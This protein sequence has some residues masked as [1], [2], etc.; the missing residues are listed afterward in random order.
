MSKNH[1]VQLVHEDTRITSA[2]GKL[3][4]IVSDAFADDTVST[5]SD[6]TPAL[7]PDGTMKYVEDLKC[8]FI[9]DQN[10]T[11]APD[12]ITIIDSDFGGNWLRQNPAPDAWGEQATWYI[13]PVTGIDTNTGIDAAHAIKTLVEFQR[14][15]NYRVETTM[16]VNVIGS[17][18]NTDPLPKM[19]DVTGDLTIRSSMVQRTSGQLTGY[20]DA[21]PSTNTLP[22]ITKAAGDWSTEIGRIIHFIESDSWAYVIYDNGAGAASISQPGEWSA[23]YGLPATPGDTDHF[24]TYDITSTAYLVDGS[25]WR[26]SGKFTIEGFVICSDGDYDT[27]RLYAL[28]VWSYLTNCAIQDG[29]A[30]IISS[31]YVQV[32]VLRVGSPNQIESTW[33]ATENASTLAADGLVLMGTAAKQS[34]LMVSYSSHAPESSRLAVG[35]VGMSGDRSQISIVD[36]KVVLFGSVGLFRCSSSAIVMFNGFMNIAPYGATIYGDNNTSYGITVEY[37][38]IIG[39]LNAPSRN[40]FITGATGDFILGRETQQMPNLFDYAGAALP[41]KSNCTTWDQLWLAPFAGQV[42]DYSANGNGYIGME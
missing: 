2:W 29:H 22:G 21:I 11:L 30:L 13:N 39:C 36:G 6:L 3:M 34:V 8:T 1:N 17:L 20:S 24:V 31:G 7:V 41:N 42:R 35:W 19:I 32:N 26:I 16:I 38:R 5:P 27:A 10:S 12:A 18:P 15:V 25:N 33:F 9:Y 14:R 23:G 40:T 4:R 37:G 28:G